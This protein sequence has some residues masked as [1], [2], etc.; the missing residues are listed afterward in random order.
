MG[1]Y[2][3]VVW[4]RR[5]VRGQSEEPVAIETELGWV[6]SGPL[7]RRYEFSEANVQEV[8]VNFIS[9]DSAGL[10]KA[11]LD[12]EVSRLW[13]LESLGIKSSDEVHESF[14]NE[15]EFLEGRYS[16]K[17]PWKLGHDPLPSNFA[18]SV[19]RMKGQLKRLKR[20]P[21]VLNEYDSIIKEQRSGVKR[22][23]QHQ[24]SFRSSASKTPR[25]ALC[26]DFHGH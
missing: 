10:D 15:I 18:N 26:V 24:T 3:I 11:S 21:E 16:V 5:T 13:D 2:S 4:G 9:Q 12:R 7:K 22:I 23:P 8:S 20:E 25:S 14:E 1:Y 6:L 19:S 17:L